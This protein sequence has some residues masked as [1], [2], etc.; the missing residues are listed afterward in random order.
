MS[1]Y[2]PGESLCHPLVGID[3]VIACVPFKYGINLLLHQQLMVFADGIA[4]LRHNW[5]LGLFFLIAKTEI[6]GLCKRFVF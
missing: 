1:I 5:I 6:D 3:E 4:N 2:E